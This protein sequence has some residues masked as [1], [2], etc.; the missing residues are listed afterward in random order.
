MSQPRVLSVAIIGCGSYGAEHAKFL[1]AHPGARLHAVVDVDPARAADFRT[2][3]GAAK[4][5]T[6]AAEVFADP[7][8][9][10]VWICTQHDAHAPLAVAA[11]AAGKHLFIEKPLALNLR[12]CDQ[13]VAAVAKAGVTAM[14]GFKFR[15]FHAVQQARKFLPKPL[16]TVAHVIDDRWPEDFWAN[17][18]VKGGGNVLSEGC[19]IVDVVLH[20]HPSP[21]VRVYA[22][23]GNRH[24][25]SCDIVDTA[26]ITIAF[27]DGA[28]ANVAVGDVGQ[29]PHASKFALQQSDGRNSFSL[30]NRLNALVTRT[31]D[32][33]VTAHPVQP[34]EGAAVIDSAFLAA[35]AAGAPSPCPVTA[36]RRATAV[37]LAAIESIR[38]HRAVDLTTGSYAAAM[39]V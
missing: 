28:A 20:L 10:A 22:E 36:G 12:E 7:G 23:G 25:P 38:T 39:N 2:R 6:D 21:A 14:T 13:I 16:L 34:E 11:A 26:A 15:F 18:P 31:S 33:Q 30:Y 35:L 8:V 5:C 37:L 1:T 27:A 29:P 19:H 9:D 32:K 4:A 17:D 3:F 24:H